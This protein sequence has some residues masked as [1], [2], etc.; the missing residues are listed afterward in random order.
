MRKD[1]AARLQ[2]LSE[3]LADAFILEADPGAG[4]RG[5]PPPAAV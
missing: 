5:G 1:Q 2:E 4:A 3:Q